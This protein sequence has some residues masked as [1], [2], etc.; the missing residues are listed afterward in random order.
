MAAEVTRNVG[1]IMYLVHSWYSLTWSLCKSFSWS[2]RQSNDPR[3]SVRETEPV[4]VSKSG[5]SG[6]RNDLGLHLDSALTPWLW[7]GEIKILSSSL[8]TMKWDNDI[9]NI[10]NAYVRIKHNNTFKKSYPSA[11]A[12]YGLMWTALIILRGQNRLTVEVRGPQEMPAL[13]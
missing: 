4:Q 1:I 11:G 8:S 3:S 12:F 2:G 7:A 5:C 10:L 13:G 9:T 6:D